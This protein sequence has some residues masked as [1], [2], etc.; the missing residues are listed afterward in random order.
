MHGSCLHSA[1]QLFQGGFLRR[2]PRC[3]PSILLPS[4]AE[5]DVVTTTVNIYNLARACDDDATTRLQR[6]VVPGADDDGQGGNRALKTSAFVTFQIFDYST[7]QHAAQ[8]SL[9]CLPLR[10][11]PLH[12]DISYECGPYKREGGMVGVKPPFFDH[13][14]LEVLLLPPLPGPAARARLPSLLPPNCFLVFRLI[15]LPPVSNQAPPLWTIHIE[16]PHREG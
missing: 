11:P 13:A 15:L 5:H 3:L 10:M 14:P 1:W 8:P 2:R 6:S 12:S 7:C 4:N 16:Q 9:L